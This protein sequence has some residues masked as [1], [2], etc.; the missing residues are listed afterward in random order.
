MNTDVVPA[1]VMQ[2][3]DRVS[4]GFLVYSRF[5]WLSIDQ[6][7]SP[8]YSSQVIN[9]WNGVYQLKNFTCCPVLLV[10]LFPASFRKCFGP[11]PNQE[12][13]HN[14]RVDIVC[15]LSLVMFKT[16]CSWDLQ[17]TEHGNIRHT[18]I[19]IHTSWRRSSIFL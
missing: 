7:G 8:H 10:R 11:Y 3:G 15:V 19:H 2:L 9:V 16:I 6:I 13:I 18:C 17:L 12:A 4:P 14:K 5:H 1:W